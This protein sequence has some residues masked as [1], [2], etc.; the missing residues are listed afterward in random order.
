RGPSA[1]EGPL[2]AD[3]DARAAPARA[4][5]AARRVLR[6][7]R[8]P[9]GG[10]GIGA[11]VRARRREAGGGGLLRHGAPVRRL[12]APLPAGARGSDG[13]LEA[14]RGERSPPAGPAARCPGPPSRRVA[15]APVPLESCL[16]GL[17]RSRSTVGRAPVHEARVR[18]AAAVAR[19]VRGWGAERPRAGPARRPRG[20]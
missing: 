1:R 3:R 16:R 8:A 7:L 19:A 20:T 5:D 6:G 4:A 12:R 11:H 13:G 9:R 15:R 10:P 17:P 18:A 14:R 2:G